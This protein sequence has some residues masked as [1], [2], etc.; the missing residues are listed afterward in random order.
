MPHQTRL[1]PDI[2]MEVTT[3]SVADVVATRLLARRLPQEVGFCTPASSVRAAEPNASLSARGLIRTCSNE[4]DLPLLVCEVKVCGCVRHRDLAMVHL[5]CGHDLHVYGGS[6]NRPRRGL[7]GS[8]LTQG[9][10]LEKPRN[11]GP[12][13][14]SRLEGRYEPCSPHNCSRVLSASVW[15]RMSESAETSSAL[16]ADCD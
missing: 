16:W 7:S 9:M 10:V 2:G 15:T 6:P 13:S 14:A 4:F 1:C 5:R 11:D 3:R 12:L 8:G